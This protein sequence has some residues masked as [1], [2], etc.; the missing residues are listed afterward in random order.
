[1]ITIMSRKIQ[2]HSLGR[3]ENSAVINSHR[4]WFLQFF[5]RSSLSHWLCNRYLTFLKKKYTFLTRFKHHRLFTN[6]NTFYRKFV[7]PLGWCFFEIFIFKPISLHHALKWPKMSTEL[8]T[9]FN[10]SLI[11]NVKKLQKTKAATT[12][13]NVAVMGWTISKNTL[14][15]NLFHQT[16]MISL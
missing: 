3:P 14:T 5:Y 1:M 2:P 10:H 7:I 13:G 16:T 8:K 12:N 9:S 15:L 6:F 4:S 11:T